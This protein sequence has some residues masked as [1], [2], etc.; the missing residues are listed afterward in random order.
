MIIFTMI[1][2]DLTYFKRIILLGFYFVVLLSAFNITSLLY[3][4]CYA[5]LFF[6]KYFLRSA[7]IIYGIIL[8]SAVL[9]IMPLLLNDKVDDIETKATGSGLVKINL[10]LNTLHEYNYH[11]VGLL[12]GG[13][14]GYTESTLIDLIYYFGLSLTLFFLFLMLMISVKSYFGRSKIKFHVFYVALIYLLFVQNSVFLP[15]NLFL[16]GIVLGV[17]LSFGVFKNPH[18]P[19]R[20]I[21]DSLVSAEIPKVGKQATRQQ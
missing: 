17:D 19:G 18:Q 1:F 21:R 3:V 20:V 11:H 8:F 12:F 10:F 4:V 2:A 5:L 6:I 15:L 13:I 14:P 16:F 9:F 7:R